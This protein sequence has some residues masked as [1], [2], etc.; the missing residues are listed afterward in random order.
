MRFQFRYLIFHSIDTMLNSLVRSIRF[1]LEMS[2]LS[3]FVTLASACEVGTLSLTLKQS[4]AVRA[5]LF[6][7]VLLPASLLFLWVLDHRDCKGQP[8]GKNDPF[9]R[10]QR[11]G[12]STALHRHETYNTMSMQDYHS[13]LISIFTDYFIRC[14][15]S[16]DVWFLCGPLYIY[17]GL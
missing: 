2:S 14:L 5:M 11:S 7:K 17:I 8:K 16:L 12:H 15:R 10:Y 9:R 13:L 3:S 1:S 6:G 4:S